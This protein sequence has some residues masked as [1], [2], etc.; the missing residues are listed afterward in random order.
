MLGD[1][2]SV[3]VVASVK[4]GYVSSSILYSVYADDEMIMLGLYV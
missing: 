1:V 3:E 2:C 4:L